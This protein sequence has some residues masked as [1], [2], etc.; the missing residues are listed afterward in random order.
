MTELAKRLETALRAHGV[1]AAITGGKVV[2]FA[3]KMGWSVNLDTITQQGMEFGQ[4]PNI[5]MQSAPGTNYRVR[6]NV[7]WAQIIDWDNLRRAEAE[8][9][10]WKHLWFDNTLFKLSWQRMVCLA[11]LQA[12]YHALCP[13]C[14]SIFSVFYGD[15][16]I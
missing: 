6:V 7:S 15:L 8:K 12:H 1:D 10:Q 13:E 2:L 14:Q 4:R 11:A 3:I 9:A 16:K 5:D